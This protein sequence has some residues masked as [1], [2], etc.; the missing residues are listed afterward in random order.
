MKNEDKNIIMLM[1]DITKLFHEE[2]KKRICDDP[3]MVTYRPILRAL[4]LHNGCNQLEIV[5]YTMYKAPTISITLKNMEQDGLIY[6][7]V[8]DTDKRNINIFLTE[9]GSYQNERIHTV[10]EALKEEMLSE[11]S[12]EKINEIKEVLLKIVNKMEENK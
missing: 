9:K 10:L 5:K 2:L 7:K 6:R 11:F 4:R 3:K 12:D 1:H 8:S